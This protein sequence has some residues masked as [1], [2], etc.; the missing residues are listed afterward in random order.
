LIGKKTR[1]PAVRADA[2]LAHEIGTHVLTYYNGR[3]QP[4]RQLYAGLAGYD[5]LQEGLAVL[6]EYLVGGLTGERL[7]LLA[8][9]V[10]AAECL[11]EGATF[12]DVFR[13]LTQIRRFQRETAF[14]ITARVFR[15]GGLTK[16]AVYLRGLLKVLDY[17]KHAGDLEPLYLGKIA[18]GHIPLIKE[19]QWRKVLKAMPLRP[20]FLDRPF[21]INR[22][23][24]LR[25]GYNLVDLAQNVRDK[26][27]SR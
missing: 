14:T 1:I 11:V 9:R 15:G 2:M 18:V 4:F 10:E 22:L 19:L 20:R 16:D 5:E 21:C 6:A 25:N 17:F 3:A 26:E 8:A 24:E 23:R 12:T 13:L 27:T 7:R